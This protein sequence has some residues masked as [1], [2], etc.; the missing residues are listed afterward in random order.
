MGNKLGN[1]VSQ[2]GD[3]AETGKVRTGRKSGNDVRGSPVARRN[4]AEPD[5]RRLQRGERSIRVKSTRS[6]S[7]AVMMGGR[8]SIPY[9]ATTLVL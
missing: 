2:G 7:G 4:A 9:P 3:G 8:V 6:R 1:V 5:Q